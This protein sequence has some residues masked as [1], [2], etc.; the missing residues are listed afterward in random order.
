MSKIEMS[1]EPKQSNVQNFPN[2]LQSVVKASA[3]VS[4]LVFDSA[5]VEESDEKLMGDL[6]ALDLLF[7]NHIKNT[8]KG[9]IDENNEGRIIAGAVLLYMSLTL[10]RYTVQL[11]STVALLSDDALGVL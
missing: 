7:E 8:Y 3:I 11:E 5:G 9:T 10:H 2:S 6:K 4:K 1:I